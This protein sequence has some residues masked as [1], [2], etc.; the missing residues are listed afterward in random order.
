MSDVWSSTNSHIKVIRYDVSN[1][2]RRKTM[3]VIFC[4][5]KPVGNKCAISVL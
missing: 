2:F 4:V 1:M 5:H 3:F